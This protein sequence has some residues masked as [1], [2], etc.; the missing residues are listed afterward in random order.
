MNTIKGFTFFKSYYESLKNLKEKDKKEMINAILEYVFDDKIP[1]FNGTK[2]AVWLLIEPN[3]G[4]SKSR[5]NPYSG[6]PHGNSNASKEKQS[7]NNQKTINDLKD[8]DKDKD[9]DKEGE[10]DK[11]NISTPHTHTQVFDFCLATFPEYVEE[12][13]KRSCEKFFNHYEAKE[14]KGIAN[15][16]AKIKEWIQQDI[17]NEKIRVIDTSRRLG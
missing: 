13:L 8:K 2:K 11:D 12:D 6:A 14:W 15:W 3:L 1:N 17:D 4:T 16:K 10:R 5:S 7:K 9:K